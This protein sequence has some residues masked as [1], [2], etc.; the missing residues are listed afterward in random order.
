[1]S[2][3]AMLRIP[4]AV[5]LLV[6]ASG[7]AGSLGRMR[8]P[9]SARRWEISAGAVVAEAMCGASLLIPHLARSGSVAAIGLGLAFLGYRGQ[10]RLKAKH[11]TP[12][13]DCG[14]LGPGLRPPA[15]A[16]RTLPWLVLLGGLA[17]AATGASQYASPLITA[18]GAG[19]AAALLGSIAAASRV[20]DPPDEKE[21]FLSVFRSGE[22]AGLDHHVRKSLKFR[23]AG[24]G[25][26]VSSDIAAGNGI[27]NFTVRV[28][29]RPLGSRVITI[30][31][32]ELMRL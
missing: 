18:T 9:G 16:E 29:A 30:T 5:L 20:L 17:G 14:C 4:V 21:I 11:S 13:G 10:R 15:A 12:A 8:R 28:R 1:M 31:P 2:F 25:A 22:L 23:R 32:Q 27:M 3:L 7:K 6:A 19:L 26:W 24:P